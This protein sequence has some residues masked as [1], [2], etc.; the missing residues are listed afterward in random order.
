MILKEFRLNIVLR[1]VIITG[2]ALLL[3]YVLTNKEWF[4][5]P[6]VLVLLLLISIWSLIYYIE[7]TNKDLTYFILSIKQSGFT[8]SFPPGKKG[9]TFKK[10]SEAFNDVIEEFR[11]VNLQRETHYQYLQTLTE[12]I[13]AGIISFDETGKIELANPAALQLLGTLRL[14]NINEIKR[15][16]AK[17]FQAMNDLMP[18]QR[19]LFRTV[20][21]KKEVHLSVQVKEL[22]MNEVPYKIMLVQDL[23]QE[24][25]EQE[26][27][28]W[29]KLIR[30]LT[31]E[32]MNSVTPI[33]SL[34]EA[35]N[36]MLTESDGER[37]K[38]EHLDEEDKED[39]FGSLETIEKRSKGLLRFVNAYKDFTKTPEIVL[40]QVDVGG[41]ITHVLNLLN[42]EL[43]KNQI[44]IDKSGVEDH[45]M[46]K[47]DASWMEQV[48]IN[49]IRNA[50]DALENIEES[51]LKIVAFQDGN[52]NCIAISD[53]GGGMDK[54]T[55]DNIFVPFFTTKKNGTGVGLSLSKQIMKLHKGSLNVTSELGKGTIVMME[56]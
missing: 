39:L 16:N 48:I 49:V 37:K 55:L 24:M 25:E 18:G 21:A 5:T 56:W 2:L 17:L 45:F 20:I 41:L 30:V 40:S 51:K 9:K 53:N 54:G 52:R 3:S 15:I 46:A 33:V 44:T 34:T 13:Q 6:L 27:D 4:F 26:V 11:K 38:L 42:S 14:R 1:V 12:N 32:I 35:V 50:I 22:V 10:L 47:A 36:T 29:Q 8:T 28:A 7:K 23:N 31:H 19:Q 43:V